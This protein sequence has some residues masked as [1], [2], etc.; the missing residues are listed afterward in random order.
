LPVPDRRDNYRIVRGARGVAAAVMVHDWHPVQEYCCSRSRMLIGRQ[1]HS[2]AIS[3]YQPVS[4]ILCFVP[5]LQE[6]RLHFPLRFPE[7]IPCLLL[8][9][10]VRYCRNLIDQKSLLKD[11]MRERIRY[12]YSPAWFAYSCRSYPGDPALHWRSSLQDLAEQATAK[13]HYYRY[14]SLILSPRIPGNSLQIIRKRRYP[15]HYG[16]SLTMKI[17]IDRHGQPGLAGI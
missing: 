10:H 3:S 11:L 12:W 7:K 1:L 2:L 16:R 5:V 6:C 13:R 15:G 4:P 14:R 17:R 9:Q 8:H